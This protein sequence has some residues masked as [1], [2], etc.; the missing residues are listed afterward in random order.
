MTGPT[1]PRDRAARG[2]DRRGLWRIM[3]IMGMFLLFVQI[4]RTGGAVLATALRDMHGLAP[5]TI[6]LVTGAMFLASAAIQLP[7]G[8]MLD[9]FGPRRMVT[10]LSF[11]AIAGMALFAVATDAL[12]LT[13]ARILIGFGHGA[14]ITGIYLLVVAWAPPE[15]V[16]SVAATVIAVAGGLGGLLSTAP[17]AFS[18]ERFGFTET[19]LA[20]A[21]IS[22][23][24]A[25]LIWVFVCDRPPMAVA[26]R[27]RETLGEALRGLLEVMLDRNLRPIFF[28]ALGFSAPFTTVGGLWAG[29][30]LLDVFGLDPPSAGMVLLIM[31]MCLNAGTFAYGPLNQIFQSPKKLVL[32]GVLVMTSALVVL[33]VLPNPGLNSVVTLLAVFSFATPI[34]VTLAAHCRSFVPEYR[35]GRAIAVVNLFGVGFIFLLQGV[36]GWIIES[37]AVDGMPTE[38]GYR[39]VFGT[40]ALTLVIT[41]GYY[42]FS[43]DAP[44][45]G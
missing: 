31:V 40:V 22:S 25:V 30:Y 14:S 35:A 11:L 33:A 28:M 16:A 21:G 23:L 41:G 34:F 2:G 6:G 20:L 39:L 8:L 42:A 32:G 43:K 13:A 27:P 19:F 12:G 37:L 4:N 45:R 24:I 7:V 18:L 9:R 44:P 10:S 26:A 29:P 3:F 15:R 38:F 1:S 17:L 36:T 5:A